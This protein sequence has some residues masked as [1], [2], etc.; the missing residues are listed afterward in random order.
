MSKYE[1]TAQFNVQAKPG[2]AKRAIEKIK[3]EIKAPKINLEVA[4]GKKAAKDI[5]GVANATKGL[6]SEAKAAES[7]VA[8]MSKMFGSALKNVLRYD[9]ARRVFYAFAGAIEQGVKDAISFE[10]EMVKISQVSGQTMQQLK[11]LEKTVSSL[12]TSLGVSS[13][14]LVRVGLILKQTGLSVKDTEIAM[15]ALAKT[16]LAPTFDNI[17]DTAETAVAAM[18]QFGLA[19]SQLEGLLGKINTVAANFAVEASDIG[20]AIKRAGGAF[21][22]AG[23]EVEE[24]IALFTSVR[25]TTRETAET[26]ATG[27]RTIFTRLQRPTTIKFLR[28]FGIELTD[29][30]GKFIGPYESVMRLNN[31]LANLDPR[32]LRFSAIVEQL[33][34]FRQV[35]KVI[36]LIQE[37]SVS[38]AAYNAQMKAADSLSRDAETAQQ[39]LAVQMQKLTEEVKEL[40]REMADSASFQGL[41]TV[42]MSLAKAITAVGKAIAPVI[43]LITALFAVKGAAFLGGAFKK[44]GFGGLS[45][46]LGRT[47]GRNNVDLFGAGGKVHKFSNGGWVPG[48]GNSDTVPALLQPGE[49]VLRKSAAQAFGPALD[50]INKYN[51]GGKTRRTPYPEDLWY[52]HAIDGD[53]L[54]V[55]YVPRSEKINTSS[56]LL[57]YDAYETSTR[58][59]T[60]PQEK[61][62]GKRGIAFAAE[63]FGK[64]GDEGVHSRFTSAGAEFTGKEK[65]GRLPFND[66][67]YGQALVKAGLGVVG[68]K[69]GGTLETKLLAMAQPGRRIPTGI[70][71]G[72]A[73]DLYT[74]WVSA[75]RKS[76]TSIK[77]TATATGQTRSQGGLVPSLLTPGEF[78]VNKQSAK[79]IGYNKLGKMNRYNLGGRVAAAGGAAMGAAGAGL[80]DAVIITSA[81]SSIASF[82]EQSGLLGESLGKVVT[83]FAGT[84][85]QL[86]GINSAIGEL[87]FLKGAKDRK[88]FGFFAGDKKGGPDLGGIQ[89]LRNRTAAFAE[90]EAKVQ[91]FTNALK[92]SESALDEALDAQ[93]A[94]TDAFS[95]ELTN[96][97]GKAKEQIA[98]DEKNL[99]VAKRRLDNQKAQNAEDRK[100]IAKS[101]AFTLAL[102]LAASAAI[103]I[104]N[105]MQD[106]ARKAIAAGDF[107]AGTQAQAAAGGALSSGAQGAMMG[108]MAGGKTGGIWGAAIGGVIGLGTAMF[109]TAKQIKEVK[110]AQ[111]LES[112]SDSLKELQAG[113]ITASQGLR[114]LQN[115]MSKRDRLNLDFGERKKAAEADEAA[116]ETFITKLSKDVTSLDEFQRVLDQDIRSL[117][118]SGTLRGTLITKLKGEIEQRLESE[119]RLREYAIAQREATAELLRLKGIGQVVSEL[120]GSIQERTNIIAGTAGGMGPIGSVSS[121]FENTPRSKGGIKRFNDAID[122][123][124]DS[125]ADAGLNEFTERVKANA[126]VSREL[127][128]VLSRVAKMNMVGKENVE[129][130]LIKELNDAVGPEVAKFI[131]KDLND[132]LQGVD[133]TNIADNEDEIKEAIGGIFKNSTEAVE[134]FASLI[135]A[136]N[137]FLK[138]SFQQLQSIEKSYIAALVKARNARVK[139]EQNF[140]KNTL[141]E[142]AVG[143]SDK[144]VQARFFARLD[145]LAAPGRG[146]KGTDTSTRDIQALGNRLIELQKQQ[147]VENKRL[148]DPNNADMQDREDLIRSSKDLATEIDSIKSILNEYGNSQQRL[149]ALNEELA[150][151]QKQQNDMQQAADK[152]IFG[153]ASESNEAAKHVSAIAKAMSEGT[154]MNL[155]EDMR[156]AVAQLFKT[157]TAEQR[158][159]YESDVMSQGR[160]AGL[161]DPSVL[162]T[163][164]KEVTRISKAIFEIEKEAMAA[165]N[166]LAKAEGGRVD[167]MASE[168]EN[169]NAQF[170][171]DMRILFH[172]ERLRQAEL[173]QKSAADEKKRLGE[174]K[175]LFETHGV[176]Q[177]VLNTLK[178]SG[179][180]KD[181]GELRRLNKAEKKD[182]EAAGFSD[183]ASNEIE[184]FLD[185]YGMKYFQGKGRMP[186]VDGEM[187]TTL[188]KSYFPA[189]ESVRAVMEAMGKKTLTT[190]VSTSSLTQG[191]YIED[192]GERAATLGES[193]LSKYSYVIPNLEKYAAKNFSKDAANAFNKAVKEA[194]SDSGQFTSVAVQDIA[195]AMRTAQIATEKERKALSSDPILDKLAKMEEGILE[196]IRQRAE[197]V[198]SIKALNEAYAQATENLNKINTKLEIIRGLDPAIQERK[199]RVEKVQKQAQESK[200]P[201]GLDETLKENKARD[202]AERAKRKAEAEAASAPPTEQEIAERRQI[203]QIDRDPRRHDVNDRARAARLS[204][205]ELA[206]LPPVDTKHSSMNILGK[207]IDM[208]MQH[209]PADDPRGGTI[210]MFPELLEATKKNAE[211][212]EA[213]KKEGV[214]SESSLS[215]HDHHA[216]PILEEILTT[217]KGQGQTGAA[218]DG[219]TVSYNK[220]DTTELDRSINTFSGS[221]E[222]LANLMSGPIQM[223][224]GGEIN[225]NVNLSG[226]EMLQE[227]EGAIAKIAANKVTQG[228]NNFVRNGLRSTSIAIKGD[229]TA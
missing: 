95:E 67:A 86:K 171:R 229:W 140:I 85:G 5:K 194:L 107:S 22:A 189:M 7:N 143:E 39:S 170:L 125:G 88:E 78:V 94:S 215:V 29:L 105:A 6:A 199:E 63:Y 211:A 10:R 167:A 56:R 221:I 53:S 68:N 139:A 223:E 77:K 188:E 79:S 52:D 178:D 13:S 128:G 191:G 100:R 9:I 152:L 118:T 33:G 15:Q 186:T 121:V 113:T 162:L 48:T 114:N 21:K 174:T 49:F 183:Y 57:G 161:E 28:Q 69:A 173:E 98:V 36:P 192:G 157:G 150:R 115:Q 12:A 103:Q 148:A 87:G 165:L 216:V 120:K 159:I 50:G 71:Q 225:V 193:G 72:P 177:Q 187:Q 135:D 154:L 73:G 175:R 144:S 38:Q 8:S 31:A 81:I 122:A 141:T 163:A 11:G 164:S 228:I 226:A 37:A 137:S 207:V 42:A 123:I 181:V 43:P 89:G 74:E 153:S 92:L 134:E 102:E 126:A 206:N 200:R 198:E 17:A 111:S 158:A 93:L 44:G 145:E 210:H 204:E 24:L 155:S 142:G 80:M 222:E 59:G 82:A 220:I 182:L 110:F 138:T 201:A 62:L 131:K 27:F 127:E 217:L 66:Q 214:D 46:A 75:L 117:V 195:K 185:D 136:R 109:D 151:A 60:S 116:A 14:S 51:N 196:D 58:R 208:T 84:L 65:Y 34:G 146:I 212:S 20:V 213:I 160:M 132:A 149:T 19:S 124:G 83:E 3:R 169:Q 64:L 54:N 55:T 166:A 108:F 1:I 91:E 180:M 197:S 156:L 101:K 112:V 202:A 35:S 133:I 61:M 172:E 129:E 4:G 209:F 41:V 190:R 25:S 179:R 205:E 18:R 45:S 2:S 70:K 168:I 16:E 106:A 47:D 184:D 227:N 99:A 176:D 76:P 32:D 97:T 40:F 30:N 96:A 224:V 219:S 90:A 218:G 130:A 203:S 119:K 26:I 147:R 23:G 104:G